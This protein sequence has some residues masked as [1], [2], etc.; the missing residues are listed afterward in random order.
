LKIYRVEKFDFQRQRLVK[1]EDG[2]EVTG[3][4]NEGAESLNRWAAMGWEFEAIVG[5]FGDVLLSREDT[6]DWK[7]EAPAD[8]PEKRFE[9]VFGPNNPNLANGGREPV[10]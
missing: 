7:Y 9:K 1:S 8:V 2:T 3:V 6:R 10:R 5:Q 4:I